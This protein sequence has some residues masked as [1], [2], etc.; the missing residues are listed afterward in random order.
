ATVHPTS[1]GRAVRDREVQAISSQ[2]VEEAALQGTESDVDVAVDDT[3][4][5]PGPYRV[6][7]A[8]EHGLHVA[9]GRP[10]P[11]ARLVAG[12]GELVLVQFGGQIHESPRHC[13]DGDG[14]EG[15]DLGGVELPRPAGLDSLD[16]PLARG[17]NLSLR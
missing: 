4:E 13:R 5:P 7:P 10:V 14:I 3:A 1:A 11:H 16:V 8:G 12:A 6:G 17:E 9:R 2:L 15:G